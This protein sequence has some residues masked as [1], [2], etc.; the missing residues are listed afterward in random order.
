MSEV[1]VGLPTN[2]GRKEARP[3]LISTWG[4]EHGTPLK[5]REEGGTLGLV[6]CYSGGACGTVGAFRMSYT[7]EGRYRTYS[8]SRHSNLGSRT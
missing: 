2:G 5:R 4:T 8:S 1:P 7:S 3:G 6:Y